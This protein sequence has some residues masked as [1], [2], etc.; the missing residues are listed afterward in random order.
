MER[1]FFSIQAPGVVFRQAG[2][3]RN[4]AIFCLRY[5]WK[6]WMKYD[7]KKE[8]VPIRSLFDDSKLEEVAQQ[9]A[10]SS[11]KTWF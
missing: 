4:S 9:A 3:G 11:S 5:L 1:T 6:G 2:G 8:A 7:C 10:S